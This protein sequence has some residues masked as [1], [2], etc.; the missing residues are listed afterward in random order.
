MKFISYVITYFMSV[1]TTLLAL[2]IYKLLHGGY[3][4]PFQLFVLFFVIIHLLPGILLFFRLKI[5]YEMMLF[6][7]KFMT[8]RNPFR[9]A[10]RSKIYSYLE[11][12]N[13][14]SYFK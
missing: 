9:D 1:G 7:V 11:K 14:K 4:L 12:N 5:G 6:Y 13:V 8:Y 10:I 2:H 3:D